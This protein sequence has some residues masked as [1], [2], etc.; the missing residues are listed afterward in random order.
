MYNVLTMPMR[1]IISEMRMVIKNKIDKSF[2][3]NS[4]YSLCKCATVSE[5]KRFECEEAKRWYKTSW[6][7]M[8]VG[9][10]SLNR[11]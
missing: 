4:L 2:Y 8:N 11:D 10:F 7:S 3:P 6:N 1:E 5:R 9:Y